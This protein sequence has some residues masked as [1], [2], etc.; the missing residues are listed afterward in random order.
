VQISPSFSL[1]HLILAAALAKLGEIDKARATAARV[2]QL[3]PDF[4]L[5]RHFAGA[6]YAPELAT[7]LTE[8]LRA[9]GLPAARRLL[10]CISPLMPLVQRQ[11][12]A[13][14]YCCLAAVQSA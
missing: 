1:T 2:L 5:G 8:A 3:Q 4:C 13:A 12:K 6:D 11:Y 14:G 10:H 9:T 7:S